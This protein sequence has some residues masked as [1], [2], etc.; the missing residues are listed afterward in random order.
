MIDLSV[1][2]LLTISRGDTAVFPLFLNRGTDLNPIR[3]VLHDTLLDGKIIGTDE[4]YFGI[5]EPNQ[6][7]ECALVRKMFT[8]KDLNKYGDVIININSSDTRCLHPGK[9]YYQIKAR[10]LKHEDDPTESYGAY[11]EYNKDTKIWSE[12][13][14]PIDY[15]SNCE[16]YQEIINTVIPQRELWLSE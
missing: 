13:T 8:K 11:L 15:K 2:G 4:V 14:L 5:M 10:F 12:V 3:Y 9:Y 6:P 1:N 7:F 16:Y